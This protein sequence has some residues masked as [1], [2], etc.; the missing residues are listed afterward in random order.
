MANKK[1]KKEAIAHY[2][3][4]IEYAKGQEPKDIADGFEMFVSINGCW[5]GE[6]CPYCEEFFDGLDD[7]E[8]ECLKC[9]LSPTGK[10]IEAMVTISC[11]CVQ[12][13]YRIEN[14]EILEEGE[15]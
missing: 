2:E 3:R 8:Y 14:P 11:G 4:M 13:Q 15:R 1:I 10:K 6:C 7:G 9:P 12:K 5:R